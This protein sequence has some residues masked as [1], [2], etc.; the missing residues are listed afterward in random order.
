[1][2]LSQNRQRL[3]STSILGD[4]ADIRQAERYLNTISKQKMK[5]LHKILICT[6]AWMINAFWFNFS[7]LSLDNS[8]EVGYDLIPIDR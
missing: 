6:W 3:I 7:W 4:F 1:M 2:H 5:V 8:Q